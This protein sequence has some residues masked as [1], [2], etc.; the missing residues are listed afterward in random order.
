M[1]SP[2]NKGLKRLAE[3]EVRRDCPIF[4]LQE[5]KSAIRVHVSGRKCQQIKVDGELNEI[6]PRRCDWAIRDYQ[7]GECLFVELK[8]SDFFHA[9][10]QIEGTIFWFKNNISPFCLAKDAYVVMS[11]RILP[12]D[13]SR[14][15]GTIQRFSKRHNCV[16]QA[17]RSG[18]TVNF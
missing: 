6:V 3:C 4:S 5:G 13:N 17:K 2:E 18:G 11:G 1:K 10:T 7:N 8:G 9:V 14:V 15:K 16:L 12:A